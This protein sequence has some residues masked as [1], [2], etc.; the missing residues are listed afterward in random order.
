MLPLRL[1]VPRGSPHPGG[2]RVC[3]T[4]YPEPS[5]ELIE[6]V[7]K[8]ED[9]TGATMPQPRW[10]N[11]VIAGG[12]VRTWEQLAAASAGS[13]TPGGRASARLTAAKAVVQRPAVERALRRGMA[14]VTPGGKVLTEDNVFT[15][16]RK[17]EYAVRGPLLLRA[18]EIEKE[19]QK[20]SGSVKTF[21]RVETC[22]DTSGQRLESF[23][24][25][26]TRCGQAESDNKD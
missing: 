4:N 15:N 25:S 22:A 10:W 2:S 16:L 3:Q 5:G 23:E 1:P 18:I 14:S 7:A 6:P 26:C 20:V 12:R 17:M 24:V 21:V 11:A 19:L 8:R 13:G 9:R